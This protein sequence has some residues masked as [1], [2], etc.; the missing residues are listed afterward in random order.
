M[1]TEQNWTE[2]RRFPRTQVQMG[3]RCVRLDPNEG[4]VIDNLHLQDISRGGLGALTDRSYYPGQRVVL[5]IPLPDGRGKRRVYATVRRCGQDR[6]QGYRIGLEFEGASV[7]NWCGV[8][9]AVA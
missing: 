2:K 6:Y 5:H 8:A 1:S 7:G 4:D 9:T 3:V